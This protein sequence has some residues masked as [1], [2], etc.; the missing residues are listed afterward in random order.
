MR[1]NTSATQS[2]SPPDKITRRRGSGDLSGKL[3]ATPSEIR[4]FR[5]RELRAA[6]ARLVRRADVLRAEAKRLLEMAEREKAKLARTP[7]RKP[8]SAATTPAK[9]LRRRG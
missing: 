5:V 9:R 1:P 8:R 7:R 4:K 3:A 6:A 2:H